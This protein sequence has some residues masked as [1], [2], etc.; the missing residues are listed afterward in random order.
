LNPLFSGRYS[1][2]VLS[3]T[4]VSVAEAETGS[5]E[6]TL[7]SSVNETSVTSATTSTAK[8]LTRRQ[9]KQM[10][11]QSIEQVDPIPVMNFDNMLNEI[12]ED[13]PP[14]C[15]GIHEGTIPNDDVANEFNSGQQLVSIFVTR[16]SFDNCVK[17]GLC[18]T[19]PSIGNLKQCLNYLNF[20]ITIN[21]IGHGLLIRSVWRFQDVD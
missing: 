8:P 20:H 4:R 14:L 5:V 2:A 19:S 6:T 17:I 9:T 21:Y 10:A 12:D 1:N 7:V 16:Q 13:F 11:S 15:E 3:E 18:S